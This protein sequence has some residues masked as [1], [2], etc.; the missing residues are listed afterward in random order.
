MR[1]SPSKLLNIHICCRLQDNPK[2]VIVTREDLTPGQQAVQSA[3]AAVNFTFEHPSRAGPWFSNSNY[4]ILLSVKSEKQLYLLIQKCAYHGLHYTIFRE[5]D[6]GN[7]ITAIAI[8]PSP[9]TQKLVSKIPLLFKDKIITN[10]T[11]NHIPKNPRH[12]SQGI[13]SHKKI[14]L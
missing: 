12:E 10:V 8:A 5:P 7:K 13:Q 14:P 6:I 3:H 9:V 2:L 4:L 11:D 1:Y